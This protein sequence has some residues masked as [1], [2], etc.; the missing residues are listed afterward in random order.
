MQEDMNTPVGGGTSDTTQ[1]TVSVTAPANG[2]TLNG[3]VNVTASAADN[4]GVAGVQFR[5]DAANLGTEDTASPYSPSWNTGTTTN[6]SHQLTAVARDAA[7]NTTTS[8]VVNVIVQNTDTQAPSAPTNL[9]ATIASSTQIN[10]TWTASTDDVGVAGYRLERQ[11]TGGTFAEIAAPVGTTYSDTGLTQSTSYVYRVRAVDGAGN[12]SAYSNLAGTT[13]PGQPPPGSQLVAAYA[14]SEGAGTTTADVSGNGNTATLI[15]PA[16]T[17]Q[18]RFGSALSF[19]GVNDYAQVAD[20]ASLDMTTGFTLSAWVLADSLSGFR[21]VLIKEGPNNLTG[22]YFLQ[23]NGRELVCGFNNGS[24]HVH[25]T[26]AAPCRPIPGITSPAPSM[27]HRTGSSV[28][29]GNLVSDQAEPAAPIAGTAALWL[30]QSTSGER[31]DGLIDEVRIYSRALAISDVQADMNT[32][33]VRIR[34]MSCR[35]K[36]RSRHPRAGR[37]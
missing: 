22:S 2:S 29:D 20:A 3:T 8:A 28:L 26:T 21:T 1:P 14:F 12:R 10:L 25:E 15:G 4:V 17:A 18:G 31:W 33:S 11:V 24:F 37:S 5:L 16:W 23:T 9:T 35:R 36:S 19:D 27:T 7:G 32:P 13:T 6:G 30:G 34:R